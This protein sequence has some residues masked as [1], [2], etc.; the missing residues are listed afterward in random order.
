MK[1][2]MTSL[3]KDSRLN[4][5]LNIANKLVETSDKLQLCGNDIANQND[6]LKEI[7]NRFNLRDACYHSFH[8]TVL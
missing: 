8:F 1:C 4:H 2:V 3:H 6:I 5:D 7:K